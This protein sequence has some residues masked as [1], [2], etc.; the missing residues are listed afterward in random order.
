MN[1][2][3]AWR[4]DQWSYIGYKGGSEP[5][6]LA[7]AFLMQRK[8]GQWFVLTAAWNNPAADVDEAAF[9][10]LMQRAGELLAGR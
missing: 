7:M 10:A 6:V 4:S 9:A 5:G 3:L 8:D 2:G 1:P